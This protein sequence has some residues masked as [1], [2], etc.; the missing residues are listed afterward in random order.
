M[1]KRKWGQKLG[2]DTEPLGAEFCL[3]GTT[4]VFL[5]LAMLW[6]DVTQNWI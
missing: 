2:G 6:G 1:L 4:G 3:P 5:A